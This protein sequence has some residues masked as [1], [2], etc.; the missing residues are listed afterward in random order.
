MPDTLCNMFYPTIMEGDLVVRTGRGD[1]TLDGIRHPAG[2][3]LGYFDADEVL[4][5]LKLSGPP[6]GWAL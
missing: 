5:Q 4:H 1:G 6:V 3:T 2:H